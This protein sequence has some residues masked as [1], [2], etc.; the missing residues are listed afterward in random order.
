VYQ[1]IPAVLVV[2]QSIFWPLIFFARNLD[3]RYGWAMKSLITLMALISSVLVVPLAAQ[4]PLELTPDEQA[5]LESAFLGKLAEVERLVS[6]GTAVNTTDPDHRTP[7]MFAA[8]NGHTAVVAFLQEK[9][10][11]ID[12]K[13]ISGR[14]ALMYASSGPYE[15]TVELLLARGADVNVQGT[16]EGFT[17]LMTAA[18]EGQV[19]VVRLLL[20]RGADPNLKDK[21]GDTAAS[22][23]RQN[24]HADVVALLES[25]Q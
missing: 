7:L 25:E 6:K 17:A 8:F 10:A 11:A 12:T 2:A 15:E 18:A 19:E 1:R 22:F 21:D 16:Y 24:G 13:D 20:D 14:T 23:A 5:L 9:G 3:L 4:T